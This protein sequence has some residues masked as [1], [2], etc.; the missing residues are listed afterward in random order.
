MIR[1]IFG[2]YSPSTDERIVSN[3]ITANNG[4]AGA[5]G[6]AF[7][8]MRGMHLIHFSD[9]RPCV[10]DV[11]KGHRWSA[12]NAVFKFYAFINIDFV[13]DSI[14]V[15]DEGIGTNHNILSNTAV[16]TYLRAV[17]FVGEVL[18]FHICADL[19][20]IIN[21]GSGQIKS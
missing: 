6:R 19:D 17:Q 20:F 11:G 9:F 4:A 3:G 16:F 14:F 8:H 10:I 15:A 21:N 1:N 5:Y 12:E 2:Y 18:I 13:L 7:L